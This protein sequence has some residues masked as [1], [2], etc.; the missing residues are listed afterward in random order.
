MTSFLALRASVLRLR[1]RIQHIGATLSGA[2]NV[3]IFNTIG[4][5]ER[6][7]RQ[8]F[9]TWS[10][11]PP[12]LSTLGEVSVHIGPTSHH[13]SHPMRK[14]GQEVSNYR[15]KSPDTNKTLL[16]RPS[17]RIAGSFRCDFLHV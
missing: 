1:T 3:N 16:I 12:T 9:N 4:H 5:P 11:P 6:S 10:R 7:G 2:Q 8:P 17:A 13:Q 14:I 15:S